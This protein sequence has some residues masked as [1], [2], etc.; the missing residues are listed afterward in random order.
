MELFPSI[1]LGFQSAL[2]LTNLAYCFLGVLL[3]TLIGVLPGIG[4]VATISILLPITFK[5][6]PIAAI[7]MLAGIYYGAQYGGSTTSILLNIPGEATAVITCLDGYQMARQGRAGPALGMAAMGSFI[8][9]TLSLLGLTFLAT[10]F[11]DFAIQFGAPE[12]FSLMVLALVVL[13]YLAHGSMLKAL[14]MALFGLILTTIGT[15]NITG[16]L[17]FT[18]GIHHLSDGFDLVPLV[19]GLFGISEVLINVEQAMGQDV[20]KTKIRNLLP[21]LQD[22]KKSIGPVLRG[23]GIGFFL[24]VLPGAGPVISS[25]VSYTV[26]KRVS[27]HPEKFGTG[28]IEGVAGPESANNASAQGAFIPLLTLGIPPNVTMAILFGALMIHG[29]QPGPLLMKDHPDFFWGVVTSMYLGN[30]MLVFL[31]LPLIPL[32]VRMLRVPYPILFPLIVLFCLV[33]AYS[34]NNSANDILVML[35]FGIF[36]YLMRRLNYEGAPLVMAFV[37]GPL[38]ELNL[39]R[40]LIV[41]EGSFTIFFTRPISAAILGVAV[42]ILSLSF[43]SRLRQKTPKAEE[44]I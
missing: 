22:W 31:N 26:E 8:A 9:G 30:L 36:G 18:L 6:T 24:G 33:G 5:I 40:S 14:I 23:S 2:Q 3:G 4:P 39:R 41:S 27:R 44:V 17:R 25:F 16:T 38:L 43:L 15:D 21:T 1:L 42:V 37:L 12:Y 34:L 19:M 13:T 20:L 35:G 10:P 11:T 32:W 28:M 7:I 29:L